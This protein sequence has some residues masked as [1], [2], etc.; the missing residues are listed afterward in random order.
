MLNSL[1]L[2]KLLI[3][4]TQCFWIYIVICMT[5][6]KFYK[7]LQNKSLIILIMQPNDCMSTNHE[8]LISVI[9]NVRRNHLFTRHCIT[10]PWLYK[11]LNHY[12]S[13]DYLFCIVCYLVSTHYAMSMILFEVTQ[14]AIDEE[15]DH[16][17]LQLVRPRGILAL[18]AQYMELAR[19]HICTG[20]AVAWT[21]VPLHNTHTHAALTWRPRPSWHKTDVSRRLD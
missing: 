20:T 5:K 13:P 12:I 15:P 19:W 10:N 18:H 8:Q 14:N 2:Y 7:T 9:W 16:N 4:I 6:P 11:V 17:V 1:F 21:L 3:F